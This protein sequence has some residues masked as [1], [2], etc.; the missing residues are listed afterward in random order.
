MSE[1]FGMAHS[2]VIHSKGG[3]QITMERPLEAGSDCT[4]DIWAVRIFEAIDGKLA[5]LWEIIHAF[6]NFCRNVAVMK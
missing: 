5:C 2:K 4:R 6:A 1:S 3:H